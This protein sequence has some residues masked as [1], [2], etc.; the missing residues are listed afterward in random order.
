MHTHTLTHTLT[1]S[2]CTHTHTYTYTGNIYQPASEE[3]YGLSL[4]YLTVCLV[5]LIPGYYMTV[6]S[7]DVLGRKLM[8]FFG[9]L[10]IAVWCS[11]SAGSFDILTNP[12][13]PDGSDHVNRNGTVRLFFI[14]VFP[15]FLFLF[16][17]ISYFLFCFCF[18]FCFCRNIRFFHL[19]FFFDN[20]ETLIYR[21]YGFIV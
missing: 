19:Y 3:V 10:M 13:E 11:A 16:F 14:S 8:Q 18:C 7:V 2:P 17:S 5:A 15:Y 20:Y 1:H 6:M 9:F 12:N 21:A 4:G